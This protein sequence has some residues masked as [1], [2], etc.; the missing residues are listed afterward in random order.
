[1]TQEEKGSTWKGERD[2]NPDIEEAIADGA[3]PRLFLKELALSSTASWQLAQYTLSS[4]CTV[5]FCR[6]FSL[7]LQRACPPRD[8]GNVW[9]VARLKPATRQ[10]IELPPE[11][12]LGFAQTYRIQY[13]SRTYAP[14]RREGGR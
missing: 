8:Y 5:V 3:N 11:A 6:L 12:C 14:S 10:A 9:M 13:Q 4:R 7:V 1:M 2:G